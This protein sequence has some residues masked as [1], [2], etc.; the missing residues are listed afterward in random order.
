[1]PVRSQPAERLFNSLRYYGPHRRNQTTRQLSTFLSSKYIDYSAPEFSLP[2]D[3]KVASVALVGAPNAGKSSLSNALIR[4]RISAVSRKVNT[5]RSRIAG[6]CTHDKRQ[7]VFWD[8]PGIVERQFVKSLGEERRELTTAG[9]GAA[10]DADV[11][12]MVVDVSR[13][14]GHWKRCASI[15]SDL[16]RVRQKVRQELEAQEQE[17]HS[18]QKPGLLLVLNKSDITR[19][20]TQ[21]LIAAEFFQ[22]H[23]EG[24]EQHFDQ[25]IFMISAYNGR[26]VDDLREALL[27]RTKLGYFEVPDGITHCGDDLDLVRQHIWEKLLHCVH[28]EVPYRC[29]FEN[30]ALFEMPNGEL[31]VS[32]V[33]RVPHSRT[34][35][36]VV[37]PGGSLI[38]WIREKTTESASKAL[39]RQ[40]NLKL[41]V[42][43]K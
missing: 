8:T 3:T 1:M 4:N 24:F 22:E 25:H 32:E 2:K 33:I 30:E 28:Q 34:V 7:L 20:K 10:A 13:R 18:N 12:V 19:P 15:S 38:Q 5:T 41:R 29:S 11:T 26:G 43:V 27:D 37:G 17:E 35:S 39:G 36:I 23:I 16:V 40:V 9:W 21:L 14:E 6:A 42:A 31:Y